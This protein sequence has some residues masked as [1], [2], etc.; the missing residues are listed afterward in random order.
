MIKKTLTIGPIKD[1][2][3]GVSPKGNT[4]TLHLV[5]CN[6]PEGELDKFTT[7]NDFS[8][9]IGKVISIN[10]EKEVNGKFTNWKEATKKSEAT[11]KS[12][13]FQKNVYEAFRIINGK[14]DELLGNKIL[15][16]EP[17]FPEEKEEILPF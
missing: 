14:L 5:E 9:Q 1:L 8:S 15:E 7:F 17:V 3:S 12:D 16:V 4:W 11:Q 13:E 6:D 2:K 10:L